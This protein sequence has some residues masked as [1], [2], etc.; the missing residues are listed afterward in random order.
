MLQAERGQGA[1]ARACQDRE[2]DERP[3]AAPDCRLGGHER[4]D[5]FDF[6]KRRDAL[7]S[8]RRRDAHILFGRREIVGVVG[9]QRR[10]KTGLAGKPKE[11]VAQVLERR[12]YGRHTQGL[13]AGTE[14]F[15]EPG[16][17]RARLFD[18]ELA[19]RLAVRGNSK[20]SLARKVASIVPS[21]LPF[22]ASKK[23]A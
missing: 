15:A 22:A 13:A 14:F 9:V 2:S 18:I 6:L 19:K 17:K 23:K 5:V 16:A 1:V 12:R 11:K 8:P 21:C 10:P 3:I 4:Q 7:F 20:R